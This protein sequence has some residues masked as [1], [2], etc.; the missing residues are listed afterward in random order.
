MTEIVIDTG[1]RLHLGFYGLR[2][3]WRLFGGLGISIDKP[4][5]HLRVIYPGEGHVKGCQY[6]N[7][8]EVVNE[9]SRRLNI[10]ASSVDVYVSNCIP[11]HRGFGSTT[12]LK[13]AIYY[14]LYTLGKSRKEVDIY[15]LAALAARG[16]VSGIGIAAFRWGGFIVDSGRP[17]Q[18]RENYVVKPIVRLNFPEAWRVLIIVPRTSWY[19]AEGR[20]EDKLMV[21]HSELSSNEYLLLLETL[22]RKIL[23]AIVDGDFEAFAEGIETIQWLTGKYFSRAQGGIYCCK[24]AEIVAKVLKDVGGKGVG[25]SSW[26]PAIYA[27]FPQESDAKDALSDALKKLHRLRIEVEHSFVSKPRNSGAIIEIIS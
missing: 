1:S 27:F 24:E 11:R 7:V 14:A 5:Y 21:M 18:A 13:L 17:L 8:K 9:A 6:E 25:Q 4:T 16:K 2:A 10:D 3:S 26:G 12:Q 15:Q 22:I 19:V 23:P 20:Q